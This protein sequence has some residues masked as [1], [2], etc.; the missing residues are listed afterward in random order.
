MVPASLHRVVVGLWQPLL[1]LE[2]ANSEPT[3]S[4]LAALLVDICHCLSWIGR[5]ERLA[6]PSARQTTSSRMRAK[7][8]ERDTIAHWPTAD[9]CELHP[10]R[11]SARDAPKQAGKARRVRLI[12]AFVRMLC[13][14]LG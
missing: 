11:T 5:V 7:S 2:L 3:R 1:D 4:P 13:S 8:A 12:M 6:P 9:D 10:E 14:E